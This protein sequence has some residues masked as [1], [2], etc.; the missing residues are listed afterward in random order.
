MARKTSGEMSRSEKAHGLPDR[1]WPVQKAFKV[2]G[3]RVV[4]LDDGADMEPEFRDIAADCMNYTVTSIE[5]MYSLYKAVEYIVRSE[6]PGDLVECGVWKGGSCMLMARALEKFGDT[7]RKIYMYD[8]FTG[9]AEPSEDDVA[10]DGSRAH[11]IWQAASEE[12]RNRWCFSSLE[13][14]RSNVLS[15][16]Y[17]A[18]N[19]VFV[20]GLVEETIPGTAPSKISV[21]RLDTDWYESTL[22]E[23]VHL[24]P[25]LVNGGVVIADDYGYWEGCRKAVDEYIA[26]N[27]VALF[28]NRVDMNARLGIKCNGSG[29]D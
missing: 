6:I 23:L 24:Y 7:S 19:L 17:P 1:F 11:A 18:G 27:K 5:R 13:E 15:T 25:L 29:P 12:D 21:L 22:H 16:G 28:L 4:R 9:M 3:C 2:F 26:E 8:T 14:V 10:I 20:P